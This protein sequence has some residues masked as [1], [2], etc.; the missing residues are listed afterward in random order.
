MSSI[1]RSR[2]IKNQYVTSDLDD[3]RVILLPFKNRHRFVL[4]A[5][6]DNTP[7]EGVWIHL[8]PGPDA[9]QGGGKLVNAAGDSLEV[10]DAS[11][12]A[13]IDATDSNSGIFLAAGGTFAED[14]SMQFIFDGGITA[15]G[16][17]N[18]QKLVVLEY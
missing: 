4:A 14:G 13:D 17:A 8:V 2:G 9:P 10:D 5:H 12:N 6:P 18:G 15:I 16:S 1:T 11:D 3:S 7:G